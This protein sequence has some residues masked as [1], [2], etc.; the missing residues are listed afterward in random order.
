MT[1]RLTD[2]EIWNKDWFLDLT[3]KQ[4][5]LIKFL[6]DNCD[7]AGFYE[8]SWRIIRMSFSSEITIEDFKNLKQIRFVND[9]TIYIEDFI[10]FQYGIKSHKDL[11]PNNNVHKGIINRLKKYNCYLTLNQ[12]LANSYPTVLVKDKDKDKDDNLSFLDTSFL[13][14]NEVEI[15][16]NKPIDY[17]ADSQIDECLKL[18]EENCPELPKLRFERR[19]KEIRELT[20]KVLGE[21][22]RDTGVFKELC[23]KA[24]KLKV[25]VDKPIDYKKML[26]CYQ[27]ILNGAYEEAQQKSRAELFMEKLR[28]E[29]Q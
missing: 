26:N 8:I 15:V 14:E 20:A 17:F 29:T 21:I 12:P 24:N 7:C 27:Q 10:N 23:L 18:Y 1:K 11:N 13:S 25:I 2:T 6:F 19:T 5:L 9:N 16:R 3:D 4:K 22:D 28:S